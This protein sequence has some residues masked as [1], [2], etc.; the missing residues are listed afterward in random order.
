MADLVAIKERF[1]RDDIPTR[2]GGIAANLA[3]LRSFSASPANQEAVNGLMQESK[4]FIEWTAAQT[5]ID[6][7]AQLVELQIEL[8]LLQRDLSKIWQNPAMRSAI[9]TH[10]KTWSDRILALSGLLDR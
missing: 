8:A 5:D 3:R 1:L 7:A 2:L 6:T 10:C 9:G 4:W